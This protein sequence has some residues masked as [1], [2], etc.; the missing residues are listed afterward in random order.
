MHKSV[1]LMKRLLAL[2]LLSLVCF[3]ANAKEEQVISIVCKGE[4]SLWYRYQAEP[5]KDSFYQSPI[6]KTYTFKYE[7]NPRRKGEMDWSMQ[8]DGAVWE[9]QQELLVRVDDP[10]QGSANF[11]ILLLDHSIF[12]QSKSNTIA[13]KDRTDI[14]HTGREFKSFM[15]VN[16]LSG[17]WSVESNIFYS[18]GN[19]QTVNLTGTCEAA[20]P[21]F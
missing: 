5:K 19:S 7:K 8:T 2:T 6:T 15:K 4:Q 11:N 12:V 17:D 14:E 13:Y 1:D 10:A 3:A 18:D 21:K 16:R 20:K 9:Y